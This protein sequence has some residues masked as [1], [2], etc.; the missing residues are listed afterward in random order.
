MKVI[1]EKAEGHERKVPR[2]APAR[3]AKVVDFAKLLE[4]SLAERKRGNAS[5]ARAA[6]DEE[7]VPRRAPAHRKASATRTR[8]KS[9]ATR[10]AQH[11]RAA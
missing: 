6:N 5:H 3:E 8:R 10:T 1:E 4:K 11:R 9:T 2:R 7:I